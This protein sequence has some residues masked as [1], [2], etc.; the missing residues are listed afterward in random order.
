MR[1]RQ[2]KPQSQLNQI[3]DEELTD[4]DDSEENFFV[5]RAYMISDEVKEDLQWVID[6]GASNHCT[7][8]ENLLINKREI[9]EKKLITANGDPIRVT[10]KGDILLSIESDNSKVIRIK[11][12]NVLLVP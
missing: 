4:N 8:F 10:I 3:V 12:T 9:E 7:P 11:L 1:L 6:S 2:A 5:E